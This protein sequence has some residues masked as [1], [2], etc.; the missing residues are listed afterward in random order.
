MAEVSTTI[1]ES[2]PVSVRA[3]SLDARLI[4]DS[5]NEQVQKLMRVVEEE[6]SL[7]FAPSL[8]AVIKVE[9]SPAKKEEETHD[10]IGDVAE[11]VHGDE[12][13]TEEEADGFDARFNQEDGQEVKID[14]KREISK[15]IAVLKLATIKAD[16]EPPVLTQE[17]LKI[18]HEDQ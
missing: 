7:E 10:K 12:G 11:A 18:L 3:A 14:I 2:L 13:Q 1:E 15:S 17:E 9:E 8:V 4:L 6:D 16:G 5:F